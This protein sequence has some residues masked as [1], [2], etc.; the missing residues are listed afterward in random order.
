MP[1]EVVLSL[2]DTLEGPCVIAAIRDVTERKL[3][4]ESLR[5]SESCFR[6]LLDSAPDAAIIVGGDG[7]IS[8]VNAQIE[9]LF[10]YTRKEL[11]GQPADILMPERF[12]AEDGDS[13]RACLG[14]LRSRPPGRAWEGTGRRKDGSEFPAEISLGTIESGGET[15]AMSFVRDITQRNASEEALR[16]SEERYRQV[17]A[18]ASEGFV[19]FDSI[20]SIIDWNSAAEAIFGWSRQEAILRRMPDLIVPEDSWGTFGDLLAPG[21]GCSPRTALTALRRGGEAFPIEITIW[22]SNGSDGGRFNALIQDVTER[23]RTEEA[24]AAARAVAERR[25]E[26]L[27]QHNREIV[28]ANEMGSLLQSCLTREEIHEVLAQFGPQLFPDSS[29]GVF[30]HNAAGNLLEAAVTWGPGDPG[31]MAFGAEECWGL[32]R[33]GPHR[34][35][36]QNL[37]PRCPH[38]GSTS[39]ACICIPM[40][41][42][43]QALGLVHLM[44]DGQTGSPQ[45]AENQR[46]WESTVALATRV[47]EHVALALANFALRDTLRQ[48]CIRDPLTGLFNRRYLDESLEREL[49]RAARDGRPLAVVMLDIDFFKTF[50]DE[51]GHGVGDQLLNGLSRLLQDSVRGGDI[52][53]R[54][55]GEE[56]LLVLPDATLEV[57]CR[58]AGQLRERMGSLVLPTAGRPVT[59]SIGVATYPAQA[60]S[61]PE[62]LRAAD[63]ALYAAKRTGRDRVEAAPP[64]SSLST[65]AS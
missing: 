61:A 52:A 60:R 17:L 38:R 2:I 37:G 42:Q 48:Q 22:P 32:R 31:R 29:G 50:N 20:G 12:R 47:A 54:L 18:T 7:N 49:H 10:G 45:P 25:V 19:A 23:R 53:C 27:G 11:V 46:L 16:A 39:C 40:M 58:R 51:H 15:V 26:E 3:A 56:F 28:T 44:R 1:V 6:G 33:G 57:A 59:V 41:A 64:V 65:L 63:M 55:G 14:T 13:R 30:L 24:L 35:D 36:P 34:E 4:E 43:N 9:H 5:A 21:S 8:L 62:L